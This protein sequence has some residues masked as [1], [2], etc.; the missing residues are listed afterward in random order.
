MTTFVSRS[1]SPAASA[2][3]LWS[4]TANSFMPFAATNSDIRPTVSGTDLGLALT[5]TPSA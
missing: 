2:S 3:P 5:T 1:S 4:M